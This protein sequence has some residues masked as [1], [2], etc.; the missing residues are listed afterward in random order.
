MTGMVSDARDSVKMHAHRESGIPANNLFR[1][2]NRVTQK[3][4]VLI[5]I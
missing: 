2:K 3:K 1:H 4:H 5:H